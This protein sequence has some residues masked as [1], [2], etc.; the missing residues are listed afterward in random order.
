MFVFDGDCGICRTWVDYWRQLTGDK[1]AY[2]PY[3]DVA[4]DPIS[5]SQIARAV[6]LIEPGGRSSLGPR[7]RSA[8]S[9]TLARGVVALRPCAQVRTA[10]RVGLF[11]PI[12]RRGLLAGATVCWG[13]T[14][15]LRD[16]ERLFLRGLG[17]I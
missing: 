8:C 7:R 11:V 9:V 14:P 13:R 12:R 4:G 15:E 2:R 5:P 3:Q 6:Q 10:E 17:L 16:R 1:V